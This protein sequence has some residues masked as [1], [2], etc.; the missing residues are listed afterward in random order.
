M[1]KVLIT[2]IAGFAGSH[3]A[4][5]L[6]RHSE[7]WGLHIDANLSNL[8]GIQGINLIECD[9]TDYEK[10]REII[11]KLRPHSVYHLAGQS[12]PSYSFGHP[13]ETL[14]TNIFSTLNI[15][16][17]ITECSPE[18][19]V[20]NIGSGD[21]YGDVSEDELPV[22]E[23]AELRPLNPYA[24][25]K[26]TQDL[27]AF[28]YWKSKGLKAVRARPFNHIG[29]RQSESFVTAEFAKRIAEIEAGK[30]KEKTLMVGNLDAAKDFSDV[31][32]MVAAYEL[33]VEK[34]SPGEVYNI[35]SGTAYR[36]KDIAEKLLS[37][38][39]EDIEIVQDPAK[40]RPTDTVAIYGD[41]S[42]VKSLGWSPKHT[43][44]ETLRVLLEYW[45]DRVGRRA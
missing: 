37:F 24:V 39:E 5:R 18:T 29:P 9:L 25:S 20:L 28:Q 43:F 15:F 11:K 21:E 3:L 45:R 13:G 44:D 38:S 41:N 26:V 42:R 1:R 36:I 32:D 16:E 23:K 10:L 33:L 2:G 22:S 30:I 35:C 8:A 6:A 14:R 12:M 19:V 27:L 34:G 4:E 31:R 17:A 40:K 7:V